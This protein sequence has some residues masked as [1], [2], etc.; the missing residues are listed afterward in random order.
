MTTDISRSTST[1][2]FVTEEETSTWILRRIA[3]EYQSRIPNSTITEIMPDTT[4]D[5]NIFVNYRLYAPCGTKTIG[6][7]THKEDDSFD[8]TAKSCDWCI[9]MS[10]MTAKLLPSEKTTMIEPSVDKQFIKENLVL[11]VVGREYANGR[12][13]TSWLDDLKAE[14][15]G[16]KFTNGQIEWQKMPD[17]Y[18][19]IDYLLVTSSLEGGHIPTKEAIAMGVPVIAPNVGWCWEYPVIRYETKDELKEILRRLNPRGFIDV[20]DKGAKEIIDICNRL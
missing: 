19:S 18:R 6:Y 13:N 9:A 4:A 16:I 5:V 7:F 12:K 2:N 10:N 3:K 14:G 17:F 11:G 1:I 8:K 15:I 20:W